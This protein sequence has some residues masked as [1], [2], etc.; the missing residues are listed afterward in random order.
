M[1]IILIILILM[2]V[3]LV[4]GIIGIIGVEVIFRIEMNLIDAIY[5]YKLNCYKNNESNKVTLVNYY[6]V[7]GKF[8]DCLFPWRWR[9]EYFIS[10]EK[11]EL[12]KDY[13]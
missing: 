9:H 11:F 5:E 8:I 4:V 12:I 13:L 7:D 10:Q 2:L 1:D 3:W 6:D